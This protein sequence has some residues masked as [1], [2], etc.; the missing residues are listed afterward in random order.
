MQHLL[1]DGHVRV[2]FKSQMAIS[3]KGRFCFRAI[4]FGRAPDDV[5]TVWRQTL[6]RARVPYF[7]I[8]D[9]RSTYAT[10]LSAGESPMNG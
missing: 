1:L 10:G 6:R 5:K 3:G 7:R 4:G 2:I 9:L 8:Y